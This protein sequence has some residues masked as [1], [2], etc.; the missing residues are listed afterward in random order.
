MIRSVL[1]VGFTVSDLEKALNFYTKVLPF[2][3][4]GDIIEVCGT[5]YEEL[6]GLFGL[7][8]RVATLRLG[9]E[10]IELTEYLTPSG[11]PIPTDS[12]SNDGWFQHLAIVVSDMD[13]AYALLRH[14][15][16]KHV[17]TAPQTLPEWNVTAA[18]IKAFYFH[19]PDGHNLEVIY[20]PSGKGEPRWQEKQQLFLGIDHTAIAV[21]STTASLNFYR[22]LLGLKLAG[23]SLNYGLEQAHLNQV[24]DAKLQINTLRA[25]CG[26][27][28]EF[29]EYLQP[30]TGRPIPADTV[31]NDLWH[32][33]TTL[34]TSNIE[35]TAA[36]LIKAGYHGQ[37][38]SSGVVTLP[39]A[40]LGFTQGFMLRDPDR[41]ALRIVEG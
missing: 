37:F 23:N 27:G 10:T 1:K 39:D 19:D 14:H 21:S 40:T 15:K 22:D 32:W 26:P 17:S 25:E 38:V 9:Q 30:R 20:F 4:V 31:A 16:V 28:I 2:E 12:R 7:R 3:P 41:H 8:M 35:A 29:L 11:R 34:A 36:T 5:T 13:A 33:Q 6:H 18:G 24:K